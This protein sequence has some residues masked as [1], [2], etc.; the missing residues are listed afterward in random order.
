MRPM[1]SQPAD[2]LGLSDPV[3]TMMPPFDHT[4]SRREILG[5]HP[6]IA[7]GAAW[8]VERHVDA[9]TPPTFLAQAADD[10]I[11]PVVDKVPAELQMFQSGRHGW[12]MG[13]PGSEVTAWPALFAT[14][15]A[16]NAFLSDVQRN[17]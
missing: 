7:E 16:M 8:S 4:R 9:R 12:G 5:E 3:L 1:R 17:G 15:A 2:F 14:W 6:S 11:S 10:P 13:K